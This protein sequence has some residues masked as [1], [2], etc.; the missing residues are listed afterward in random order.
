MVRVYYNEANWARFDRATRLGTE[1]GLTATQ[2]A[3]AWVLNQPGLE[4][5]ALVGPASVNELEQS[6][7]VADVVLSPA[8]VDWLANGDR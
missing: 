8:Q 5:F 1:L 6:L 2:V 4:T 3:L 7:A